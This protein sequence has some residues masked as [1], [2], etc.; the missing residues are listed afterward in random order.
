MQSINKT[1][2]LLLTLVFV[3]SAGFVL[4]GRNNVLAADPNTFNRLLKKNKVRNPAPPK[5]GIHN[6]Q[7]DGTYILQPPLEAFKKLPKSR[8]GNYVD[9]VKAL[10][11]KKIQPRYDKNDPKVKPII[12]DLNIIREVKGSMPDVVYPHAQHTEWL[13][14]SNCHP[15]IFI[16]QKGANQMSMASILLGKQCGV[17]HGKVAF[18]VTAS[19][20]RTCHSKAK[21]PKKSAKN[22]NV[23]AVKK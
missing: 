3:Y 2:S 20:C 14:C 17:C 5:D 15:A 11:M 8:A 23:S 1:L 13:D 6:I 9:W 18:P 16:P 7:S 12:M 10:K 4:S 19:T 22:K 21:K